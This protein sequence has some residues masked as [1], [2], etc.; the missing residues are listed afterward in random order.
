MAPLALTAAVA[1]GVISVTQGAIGRLVIA[2][3]A[4]V[5]VVLGGWHVIASRGVARLAGGLVALAAVV[6]VIALLVTSF[7]NGLAL[8]L[9][10][11]LVG[12]SVV[13]A[14]YALDS[15]A[16]D[17]ATASATT[18][19]VE[20]ARHPVLIMNPRSGGGKVDEFDLVDECGSAGIEP[21]V[22]KRG[23]DLLRSQGRGRRAEQT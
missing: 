2:A 13:A 22:L 5:A 7:R 12:V 16:G 14:R 6:T 18:T 19:C 15:P 17:T 10:L 9:A 1:A 21:V 3:V 20:G 4:L 8:E 11:L 23:D